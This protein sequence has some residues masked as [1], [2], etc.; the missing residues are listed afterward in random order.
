MLIKVKRSSQPTETDRLSFYCC[1]MSSETTT[2]TSTPYQMAEEHTDPHANKRIVSELPFEV[3]REVMPQL[4]RRRGRAWLFHYDEGMLIK[5][6]WGTR[7]S[8]SAAM[9]YVRQHAPSVPVPEM[10][11]CDFTNPRYGIIFMEEVPG[12]TLEKVW[13][14]LTTTQKEQACQDIWKIIMALRQIPRPEDIPAERCLYTTVDGSPLHPQGGLTGH[15][16]D[17]LA[18]SLHNTDDAFREFILQRYR[19]YHGTDEN[20]LQNFPRSETA[21]FTHGD[22]HPR[23]LMATADG[24]VTSLLDFEYAGFMP[25]YWEDLGMFLQIFEWDEDWADTMMRTKPSSWDFDATRA[26]C[27]VAKRYM[28]Y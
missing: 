21:V 14:S 22:I 18:Q 24:R 20:V 2:A 28:T 11:F 26:L 19:E 1:N 10:Y 23:N 13:P 8:E 25:D 4:P 17:P 3:L 16:G 5:L 9:R 7:S 12:Q 6:S 15:S 27:K